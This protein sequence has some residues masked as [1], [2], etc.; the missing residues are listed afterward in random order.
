LRSIKTSGRSTG[1]V[2]TNLRPS[3]P[4]HAVPVP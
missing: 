2:T 3:E 1:F 4:S